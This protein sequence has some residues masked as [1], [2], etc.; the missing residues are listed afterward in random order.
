MHTHQLSNI[1]PKLMP[2]HTK[3]NAQ[4]SS[5]TGREYHNCPCSIFPYNEEH[6]YLW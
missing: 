5:Y 6:Y 3:T 1:Q 4:F 2:I